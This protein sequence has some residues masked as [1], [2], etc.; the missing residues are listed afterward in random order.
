MCLGGFFL[1]VGR[2]FTGEIFLE[3]VFM[4]VCDCNCS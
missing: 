2:R 3:P 1:L 4:S